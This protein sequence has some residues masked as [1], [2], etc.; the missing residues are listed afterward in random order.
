MYVCLFLFLCHI[1]INKNRYKTGTLHTIICSITCENYM[2]ISA[3]QR[4]VLLDR[5][6]KA[7]EAKEAK[8]ALSV[9]KDPA[10]P[11]PR[12]SRAKPKEAPAPQPQTIPA[13][14]SPPEPAVQPPPEQNIIL[15]TTEITASKS[16]E[17]S[18]PT[19]APSPPIPIPPSASQPRR[20]AK[21]K[22]DDDDDDERLSQKQKAQKKAYAKVV[23]Y[24]QPSAKK[25]DKLM[26]QLQNETSESE[27]ES[28]D[29]APITREQPPPIP[30]SILRP[31]PP[32]HRR[33]PY[34][35]NTQSAQRTEYLRQLA[36]SY[37]Q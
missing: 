15:S 6:A 32:V 37:Y 31:K 16:H 9:P 11:K 22:D 27:S 19:T 14:Q 25:M 20:S 28:E 18:L 17:T 1:F 13:P 24:Q 35:M 4:Q 2:T 36:L 3:E 29:E 5:L 33:Q 26:K 12:K 21:A 8:K 10:P 34:N 30:Q 7:R 23:F